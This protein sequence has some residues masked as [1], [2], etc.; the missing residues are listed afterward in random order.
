M[1]RAF[2]EQQP[3]YE[4]AWRDQALRDFSGQLA[5]APPPCARD[6]EE[7]TPGTKP[8]HAHVGHTVTPDLHSDVRQG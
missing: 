5:A 4:E 6:D 2:L 3:R 1:Q 8:S 7:D